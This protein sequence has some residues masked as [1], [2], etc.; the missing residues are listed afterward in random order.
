MVHSPAVLRIQAAQA[1]L[2]RKRKGRV[3]GALSRNL[4]NRAM[5]ERAAEF[6]R[7]RVVVNLK[8]INENPVEVK[9]PAYRGAPIA[10]ARLDRP[11]R[12]ANRWLVALVRPIRAPAC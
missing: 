7:D 12:R 10:L 2:K 3:V 1:E 8:A 11:E 5:L 4:R 6:R 9:R